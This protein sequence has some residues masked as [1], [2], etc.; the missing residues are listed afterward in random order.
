MATIAGIKIDLEL[1]T[2]KFNRQVKQATGGLSGIK[3]G[4]AG[5]TSA[6]TGLVPVAGVTGLAF[7]VKQSLNAQEELLNLNKRLGVSVEGLSKLQ[8]AAEQ[9]GVSS[10]TLN[11]GLQRMT[12]RVSEAA[13]GTG[14][15]VK[16]LAELSVTAVELNKLAPERQFAILADAIE[17][18]ESPA[19]KVRLAMK[20]FDSE[21]VSLLQTLEGGSDALARYGE[22]A[23]ALGVTVNELAAVQAKAANDAFTR[24]GGATQGL[25]NALS[26]ALGPALVNAANFLATSIPNA[27]KYAKEA[28]EDLAAAVYGPAVGDIDRI[29]EQMAAAARHLEGLNSKREALAN[30]GNAFLVDIEE[31][32][33]EIAELQ[34]LLDL[35]N[36]FGPDSSPVKAGAVQTMADYNAELELANLR[37]Q[38]IQ[39][40]A[41][42]LNGD[43]LLQPIKI[44][45]KRKDHKQVETEEKTHLERIAAINVQGSRQLTAATQAAGIAQATIDGYGAIQKAWASAPFPANLGA[46]ALTTAETFANIAAMRAVSYEGG[47]S[48]GAAVRAGGLDGK[49]GF[50]AM[51][52]PR[53]TIAD[54]YKGAAGA[55]SNNVTIRLEGE[56]SERSRR[57]IYA[58]IREG[59]LQNALNGVQVQAGARPVF[60]P[61]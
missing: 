31:T 46:V 55:I 35:T 1:L 28:F 43:D 25:A 50:M 57:E 38:E 37:L 41:E 12:R 44:D 3:K 34:K 21:G 58:M 47:G 53:E 24:M 40:T 39:I 14:E 5:V 17:E 13:N 2:A 59:A 19:D 32:K 11:M 49:G 51:V 6:L 54:N 42:R 33:Q 4:A 61:V 36:E 16:A 45:A 18:V 29:N 20:L 30:P 8:Y 48:T 7:M 52:H 27:V 10:N 23:D 22:E 15:A 60:S 26:I 56:F 9:T